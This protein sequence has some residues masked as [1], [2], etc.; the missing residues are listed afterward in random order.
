MIE[1]L[2][3]ILVP[4]LWVQALSLFGTA[5]V[6]W[7]QKTNSYEPNS[8]EIGKLK[9]NLFFFTMGASFL[10]MVILMSDT[11]DTEKRLGGWMVLEG[12]DDARSGEDSGFVFI[13]QDEN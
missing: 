2:A 10:I 6:D 4:I 12:G 3:E 7:P 11:Q 13:F 1:P 5:G 9:A 8:G